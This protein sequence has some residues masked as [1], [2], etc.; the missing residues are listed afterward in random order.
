MQVR[1]N[2]GKRCQGQFSKDHTVCKLSPTPFFQTPFFQGPTP[3]FKRNRGQIG[4]K[5]SGTISGRQRSRQIV[6]DAIVRNGVGFTD[7]SW[8]RPPVRVAGNRDGGS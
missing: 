7:P 8:F 4:K 2:M 6:P 5:V 3:F 1:L